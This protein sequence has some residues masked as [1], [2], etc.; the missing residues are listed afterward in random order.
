MIFVYH[1]VLADGDT[2][3]WIIGGTF[4]FLAFSMGNVMA[5]STDSV[6]GAVPEA[7]AGVASA[8]NDVTRQ[9]AGAKFPRSS[10]DRI[11][12]QHGL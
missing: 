1:F 2:N 3:Y 12:H 7:N 5:P 10:S 9:V 8:M 4:F 11:R 6:M